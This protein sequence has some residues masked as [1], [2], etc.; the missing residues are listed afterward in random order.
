MEWLALL[1]GKAV[2]LEP[3]GEIPGFLGY[4]ENTISEATLP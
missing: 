1:R 3:G 2:G 4:S